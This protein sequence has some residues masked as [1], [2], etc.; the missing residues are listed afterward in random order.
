MTVQ[1]LSRLTLAGLL[2][3][4]LATTGCSQGQSP[5]EPAFDMESTATASVT[6]ESRGAD[7]PVGDDRGGHGADDPAGDDRGGRGRGNDDK[8][9]DDRRNRPRAPRAGQEFEGAV[10]AVNVAGGSLTLAGGTRIAVNAS[11][12]W[13]ARGDLKTLSEVAR[14]LRAGNDPRVEGRGTRRADGSIL[15]TT[16]KAEH[17]GD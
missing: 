5:T 11:T 1:T 2:A 15:A 9:A 13:S 10:T 16:I 6:A 14:S 8:G 12:Q 4:P 17:L 3:L 7:D